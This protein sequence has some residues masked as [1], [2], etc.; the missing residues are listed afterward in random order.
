LIFFQK[1]FFDKKDIESA[2]PKVLENDPPGET[3]MEEVKSENISS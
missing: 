1:K 3:R 2:N